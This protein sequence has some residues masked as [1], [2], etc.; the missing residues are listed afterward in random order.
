M[1]SKEWLRA[2]APV[3]RLEADGG[4]IPRGAGVFFLKH[5]VAWLVT[6]NHVVESV[7]C[8][9][10]SVLVTRSS[11]DGTGVVEVGKILRENQFPW[12]RDSVLDL[13]AAPI[14]A[15]S[16]FNIFAL[17]EPECMRIKDLVPSMQSFTAG[18]PYG[19]RG[20]D[21]DSATP[22]VLNGTIAGIDVAGG[23]IFTSVPTF[24]GN[25][26]GPLIAV[27]SPFSPS[28]GMVVGRPTVLFAGIMLQS[29]TVTSPHPDH[30]PPLHLGVAAPWDAV[31]ALL[32]STAA[33]EIAAMIACGREAER[34]RAA[35]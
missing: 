30:L 13:A 25:S 5:D 31:A 21:S 24:P 2:F 22:L 23:K 26:G 6:A 33:N 11:E 17:G 32:D 19:L 29:A 34:L 9:A 12:V 20:F 1:L 27:R 8:E 4:W 18:C 10:L 3:G 14:P 7:G 16:E 15:S 35:E 28:G